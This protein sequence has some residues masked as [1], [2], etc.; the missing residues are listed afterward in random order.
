MNANDVIKMGRKR[1]LAPSMAA[2]RMD[3]PALRALHRELDDEHCVLAE[4]A[5]EHDEADLRV[6]VV[7]EPERTEQ[8]NEPEDASR[9]G[10]QD[11]ERAG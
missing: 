8:T 11:R 7:G 2:S 10:E 6:D 3:S 5:D 4:Q 1:A 9:Q